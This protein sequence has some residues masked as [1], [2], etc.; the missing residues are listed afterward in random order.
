MKQ[1]TLT[2][3]K[4]AYILL[5]MFLVAFQF[6]IANAQTIFTGNNLPSGF[7]NL[8]LRVKNDVAIDQNNN[9]WVA[10]Q[11]IGLGKFDGANWTMYNVASSTLP[12]DTVT[13][14]TIANNGNVYATTA[15]G[16][17]VFDGIVWTH[18]NNQNSPLPA[19]GA[20]TVELNGTQAWIGTTNGIYMFDGNNWMN[21]NTSNSALGNDS[22][23]CIAFNANNEV[24]A[25]TKN[26]V[27][28]FS[29][30]V[31]STLN[32]SGITQTT[33]ADIEVL[34]GTEIWITVPDGNNY[35]YSSGMFNSIISILPP[36]LTACTSFQSENGICIKKLNNNLLLFVADPNKNLGVLCEIDT[37]HSV[38]SWQLS[39][40]HS[41]S[42]NTFIFDVKGT[43]ISCLS[44]LNTIPVYYKL[45]TA[46]IS[47]I[48]PLLL[49]SDYLEFS[50]LNVNQVR[51]RINNLGD[52]HWDPISQTPIYE[53]P[54]CTGKNSV[55]SS[56]LWVGGIDN[57]NQIHL[58]AATYRQGGAIDYVTG[59][60]DTIT[61]T[62]DSITAAAYDRVWK[63]NKTTLDDFIYNFQQGNV[64]NGTYLIPE[65]IANWPA[66]GGGTFSHSLAPFVDYNNDGNYNP[67]DGDYPSIDGDQE[68]WFIFNDQRSHTESYCAPMG[69]EI[70]GKAYAYNC[71]NA[72]P[73]NEVMNY[74]TFYQYKIINRSMET[75]HQTLIGMMVDPDLG[76]ASD[77]H[78]GCNVGL[79]TGTC[80]NLDSIDNGP[81]G[82]GFYPPYQNVTILRGPLA[83]PGDGIDNNKDGIIDEPGECNMMSHFLSYENVNNSPFG[84]PEACDDYYQYLNGIWLDGLPISYGGDG[85]TPGNPTS[86]Y[87]FPGTTDP[88]FPSQNWTMAGAGIPASD[89]RF[90][91]SSGTFTLGPGESRTFDF[92]YIYTRDTTGNW[93]INANANN[94]AQVSNV[95]Q[96]FNN[97]LI[98]C[99]APT[100]INENGSTSEFISVHPN[101]ANDIIQLG[102][103]ELNKNY[104]YIITDVIGRSCLQGALIN[105]TIDVHT[106][107]PGAYTVQ[108]I[109]NN[110]TSTARF[111]KE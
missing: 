93:P 22:I 27:S 68:I 71:D 108:I 100:A 69:L 76:N 25:G 31:W 54:K 29:Q 67:M 107:Q 49:T 91:I 38:T 70:H 44:S 46:D 2:Y 73:Y 13:S 12:S 111:I 16:L 90:T 14:V 96:W 82:Y 39:Q 106:L 35:Y 58:A 24:L 42:L 110:I 80:F 85:R 75:Y 59:P 32:T 102:N 104:T 61:A 98:S 94:I 72:S 62:A 66:H 18:Y 74:T 77:D 109:N 19:N 51:T 79:N 105:S 57:N 5:M 23:T 41:G 64:Q 88:A 52:L 8:Q 78:V 92:A 103:I 63:V 65:V 15:G 1:Q 84:N 60:L 9:T 6:R 47:T 40:P 21:Y 20:I 83:D 26:G 81:G 87:M 34:N 43:T 97:G 36:S 28:L 86:N 7:S 56:G 10:F 30:N 95:I 11:R 99:P 3:Q 55:F 50:D 48:N 53:V 37:N 17:S 101:P 33:I 45:Y 89:M 4:R